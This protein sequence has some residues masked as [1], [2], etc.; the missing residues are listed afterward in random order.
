MQLRPYQKRLIN[1]L[2]R[3]L[4]QGVQR[5]G[6]FMGTGGGKSV[7]AAKVVDDA[8]KSGKRVMFIVHLDVLVGQIADKMG[9]LGFPIGF[10]KAGWEENPEA[11]LQICSIQTLDRRDWWK[12]YP[13]DVILFDECLVGDTLVITSKGLMRIDDQRIT[14]T[15][16]LT[17]NE[18]TKRW[19][20]KPCLKQIYKGYS[21]TVKIKTTFGE[22]TCTPDHKILTTAGW[23]QA[24]QLK[25]GDKL[26]SP[27]G[28]M[29]L[30]YKMQEILK[31]GKNLLFQK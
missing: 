31:K 6:L 16:V 3:A 19:E 26:L 2:Y 14:Q 25:P 17:F 21:K 20:W 1:D 29:C 8:V 9:D 28:I 10:V 30:K 12:N 13:A 5:I 7:V 24:C 11:P 23:K 22:L 4:N 18:Q 15:D 27:L